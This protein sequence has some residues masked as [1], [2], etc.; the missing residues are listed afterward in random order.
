MFNLMHAQLFTLRKTPDEVIFRAF[1]YSK[2]ILKRLQGGITLA[3]LRTELHG[4]GKV[5]HRINN[6]GA[7]ASE[8]TDL[9]DAIAEAESDLPTN[10][11]AAFAAGSIVNSLQEDR[12]HLKTTSGFLQEVYL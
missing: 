3:I 6:A 12:L 10:Q 5:A 2:G 1:I 8:T 11:T 4:R 9:F 7:R